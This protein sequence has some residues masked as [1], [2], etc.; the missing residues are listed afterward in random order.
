ML[1]HALGGPPYS[2]TVHG[3]EEFDKPRGARSAATRCAAPRSWWRSA[4][5][6]RSQLYRWAAAAALAKVQVVHCGLEP[7]FHA[8]PRRAPPA[9]AAA[10]VRRP[11]VRAEGAAAADRGGCAR[12]RAT[13]STFE[14][15]LAGDG[16]M[17][18]EIEAADRRATACA[19]TC[20]SPAGSAAPQVRD[21]MLAARALVLPSFAEGLPVVLMEAMALRP[22]GDHDLRRRH[23]RAGASTARTAGWC[24]PATSRRWRPRCAPASARRPDRAGAHGR[25]ARASACWRRHDVDREAAKLA[26][27]FAARRWRRPSARDRARACAAA[28]VATVPARAGLQPLLAARAREP[29][30]ALA[31]IHRAAA[32]AAPEPVEPAAAG[33]RPTRRATRR[34]RPRRRA[35]AGPRRGRGIAAAVGA[36]RPQLRRRRPPARGRRQL[37]R[38]RPPR[39]ARAAGAEVV[40]RTRRRAARQGLCARLRRAPPGGRLRPRCVVVARRRLLRRA[41]ARWTGWSRP[42][43]RHGRP[44][45]ALYLMRSAAGRR[46]CASASPSSPGG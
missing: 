31:P 28:T 6:G 27:L 9:R 22:A 29:L 19:R 17:R 36:V 30:L 40:E 35:D 41:T 20:A 42:A 1:A 15:V 18:A 21:E 10:G 26:A 16:E 37:Q 8:G 24:R 34:R 5:F 46:R 11:A 25:S 38:R 23:P 3:P 14:L 33:R 43:S 2:F 45:Q 32:A 12:W 39:V 4:R 44:V 7:A 13:A